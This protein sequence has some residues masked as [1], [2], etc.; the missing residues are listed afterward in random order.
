MELPA[1][2]LIH[3]ALLGMKGT[4]ATLMAIAAEGY[5]VAHCTF[6]DRI[7]RV[8]LPIASTVVI[9]RTPEEALAERLEIER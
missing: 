5:Y 6:G 8:H 3:N 7:H 2:V 4:R 9:E 1:D